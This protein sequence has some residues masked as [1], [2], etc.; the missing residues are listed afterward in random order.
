MDLLIY[1]LNVKNANIKKEKMM[2]AAW[3]F[4][5][6]VWMIPCSL[7][8]ERPLYLDPAALVEDRV[9]DLLSRMTLEEKIQM[10]SGDSTGFNSKPVKRLGIPVFRMTDGPVGVRW[11]RSA[12]FPVSV[13][14]AA[15][16]DPALVRRLGQA[17]G[18]EA[19]GKGRNVLLGP[20]VNIHRVPHGGRN[21]ESFGEDPY[22]AA[23]TAVGYVQ[24]LQS[25]KVVATTKHFALNNQE[26]ERNS[27]DV[28]VDERAMRE[29]YLPAF[30]AAVQEGGSWSVMC[31]YNR[32][33]GHYCSANMELLT[34]I[35]KKEWGFQGFVMSDWGAV[36]NVEATLFCGLDLEMPNGEYLNP[37]NVSRV[38]REGLMK[39]ERI[40]DKVRRMLRAMFAMGY[41]E[42]EIPDGG[43]VNAPE[44]Q[45]VALEA[46]RSGIVLLKNEGLLPFGE[47][48]IKSLAVIGPNAA[49]A[50]TGGGGSSRVD[51]VYAVSILDGLKRRAEGSIDIRYA[52]GVV[53]ENDVAPIEAECL[54]PPEGVPGG[55]GLLGT[56]YNNMEFQGEPSMRRVDRQVNFRWSNGGPEGMNVDY[57]SVVWTGKLVPKESGHYALAIGSDDGSRLYV[58]GE[59]VIDNWGQHGMTVKSRV[60]ALEAGR[61]V[62]IRMEFYERAGGADAVFGWRKVSKDPLEAAAD[63]AR[64]C[65]A[66]V[67]CVGYSEQLETEGTDRQSLD[68]P[69]EQAKL[70]Q[71]VAAANPKT[72]VVLNSGAPVL[73]EGWLD[74]VPALVEAWY[75]GQEGGF[76]VADILLGKV[77]PSGKLVT[78]FMR[79]WEDCPAYGNYP[80]AND[81]VHY[82]EGIFVGYRHFDSKNLDVHFPFG[83]GLS[84]T[85]FSYSDLA[86]SPQKAKPGE[87]V[88][89]S[90]TVKNTGLR[91][92]AEVV[93]LYLGDEKSSVPRPVKELKG[94]EKIF[95]KAGESKTVVLTIKPE[96]MK[97]WDV[98]AHEWKAEPG[99]F[100]VFLGSSSRD[101]RFKGAFE[102]K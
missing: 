53:M 57:F 93:Q 17:L 59:R 66:A 77:N 33:A 81:E 32:L 67:V 18:R 6:S 62:D 52:I 55:P 34:G 42:K 51:P 74:Q 92:G 15:T 4:L 30:K 85:T 46:A 100:L 49:T 54:T 56:Y 61:P 88:R 31:A 21:F 1:K 82:A 50:R 8:A 39:E 22:L 20:C 19:K 84:Y 35:L 91:D 69:A 99:K 10:L 75:P 9:E 23:R 16:W 2:K 76:A 28:K 83:H 64:S 48:K 41:F 68:L 70:I 45:E 101:I 26:I 65:D 71:A 12:A 27:I 37:S 7:P 94:F 5:A 79:K 78:T 89:V 87:S 25:E 86:V 29:I 73:L 11:G 38:L 36:H 14:M 95:L 102:L 40:N 47:G 60:M 96:D 97:F 43:S 63:L 90:L 98:S 72:V 80:G 3:L 58:N 24:G 13:C 44:Q